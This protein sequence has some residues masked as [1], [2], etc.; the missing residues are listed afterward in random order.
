[1]RARERRVR[2]GDRQWR[3]S[4]TGD[5]ARDVERQRRGA[6]QLAEPIFGRDLPGGGRADEDLIRLVDDRP[7]RRRRER[8][9]V[10]EPPD[11][12]VGVEQDPQRLLPAPALVLGQ[13]VE[14]RRIERDAPLHAAGS[15]L[16][17]GPRDRHQL[18][19]RRLV[20]R[21]HDLLPRLDPRDKPRERGLG[22][23]D[24]D[25]LGHGLHY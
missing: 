18:R 4:L 3:K 20:A 22:D 19:H 17:L 11:E 7:A 8:A 24:G 21:N 1:M 16:G 15:A 2:D 10:G 5:R 13:R 12:D 25:G 14:E 23:V 6:R 9:V